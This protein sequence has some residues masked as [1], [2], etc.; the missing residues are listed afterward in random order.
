MNI[1]WLLMLFLTAGVEG[2]APA[3]P[4][5]AGPAASAATQPAEGSRG[6][7]RDRPM[8]GPRSD[9]PDGSRFRPGGER[10]RDD[11]DDRRGGWSD[12]RDE[13]PMTAEQIERFMT[14]TSK[15]FPE[16]HNKLVEVRRIDQEQFT[17]M[18]GRVARG[19]F[20][21]IIW[22]QE[23]NPE[24]AEQAK[25]CFRIDM[26]IRDLAA[27]Y[28][29][30]S[31]AGDREQLKS[32]LREAVADRFD[33]RLTHDE[34]QIR[35]FEQRITEMKTRLEERRGDRDRIIEEDLDRV[36]TDPSHDGRP[37][38]GPMRPGF[39]D[40]DGPRRGRDRSRDGDA[41]PPPARQGEVRP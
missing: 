27:R 15:D 28:Q 12:R 40:N 26:K 8:M 29:S 22:L 16:L 31:S 39:F 9:R 33:Q 38:D 5:T 32:T 35:D 19:P 23:H 34:Q 4:S 11:R 20:R 18:V 25:A 7:R 14:L 6:F 10:D 24:R 36:L 1:A 21:Y 13:Q 3:R 30:A 17:Q 37:G 41:P 2:Q